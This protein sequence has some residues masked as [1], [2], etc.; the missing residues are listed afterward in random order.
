MA[1]EWRDETDRWLWGQ[2]WLTLAVEALVLAAF[3]GGELFA[4]AIP[5]IYLF[6]FSSL[7][8]SLYMQ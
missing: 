1:W 8:F 4:V 2:C 3:G 6:S 5:K 7:W